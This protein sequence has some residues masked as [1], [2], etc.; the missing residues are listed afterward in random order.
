[1]RVLDPIYSLFLTTLYLFPVLSQ[2][3]SPGFE[4][5]LLLPVRPP[6]AIPYQEWIGDTEEFVKERAHSPVCFSWGAVPRL[7]H[8][9]IKEEK[10]AAKH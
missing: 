6:L 9:L 1:M 3:M 7:I 8:E 2:T 4:S 5:D 10:A